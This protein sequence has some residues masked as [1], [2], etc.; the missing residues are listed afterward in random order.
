MSQKFILDR[1]A[2]ASIL[3]ALWSS[4]SILFIKD[5]DVDQE[6]QEL[7]NCSFTGYTF[8]L[9][10]IATV[11]GAI[12]AILRWGRFWGW[13]PIE[14]WSLIVWLILGLDLHLQRFYDYRVKRAAAL[15]ITVAA[16]ALFV[17]F[18][19]PVI[20]NTIHNMYAIGSR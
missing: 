20:T 3:I 10:S 19:M 17:L 1:C 12:W 2:L 16:V 5:K 18:I 6:R 7:L 4:I 14:T 13:D 8:V 15:T 11:S 9:W